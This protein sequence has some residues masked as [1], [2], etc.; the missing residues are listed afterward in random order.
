MNQET[1]QIIFNQLEILKKLDPANAD[2]FNKQQHIID[3][4]Y[5]RLYPDVLTVDEDE[6]SDAMQKEVFD[7]LDMF[8]ALNLA[9]IAGW[10]PSNAHDARFQGFDANND[11]HY[12]FAGFLL[13]VHGRFIES[14]PNK[15]SHSSHSIQKYRDMLGE[16]S[17]A[18]N[19]FK[20]TVAEAEAI[21]RA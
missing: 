10:K 6:A 14:A 12:G 4:G 16:W 9:M 5:T 19:K 7:V 17:K 1:R 11:D 15:N 13:D 2:H 8:R 21:I 3:R 18:A 20:L